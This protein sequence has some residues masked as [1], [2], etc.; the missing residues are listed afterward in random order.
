MQYKIYDYKL[1]DRW[2]YVEA[3]IHAERLRNAYQVE[4]LF[5]L[6]DAFMPY[7][8]LLDSE[9]Y[10][11]LLCVVDG[12]RLHQH[13]LDRIVPLVIAISRLYV[14]GFMVDKELE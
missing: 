6:P 12:L 1:H 9:W 14:C 7:Y 5:Y 10:I 13:L 8:R 11:Q 2:A 4:E 3:V